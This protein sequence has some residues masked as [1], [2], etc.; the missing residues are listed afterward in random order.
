M[1]TLSV[2]N[3]GGLTGGTI[4][5]QAL[6]TS[7]MM[8]LLNNTRITSSSDITIGTT[9]ATVGTGVTKTIPATGLSVLCPSKFQIVAAGAT[10]LDFGVAVNGTDYFRQTSSGVERSGTLYVASA[11]FTFKSPMSAVATNSSNATTIFPVVFDISGLGITTGSQSITARVYRDSQTG[12]ADA[13][14][15]GTVIT[16]NLMLAVF[17]ASTGIWS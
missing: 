2:A 12:H 4:S 5:T 6:T 3:I 1:S 14:L 13:T 9:A 7:M 10:A 17:D 11:T 16:T 15:K 8:S